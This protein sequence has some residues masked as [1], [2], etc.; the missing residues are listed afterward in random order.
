MTSPSAPSRF[1]L[2][3]LLQEVSLI[4]ARSLQRRLRK[5]RTPQALTAIAKDIDRAR[6]LVAARDGAIGEISYPDELPVSAYREEIAD[7]IRDNQVVIIAG[8]TGSGK[9]TQIPKICL[10]LG[11]GRRGLIGHTQPRRLAA[12]TVAERIAHELGQPVGQTVGYAIR[13][14]DTVARRTAV[15]LMTD[16]ILL[17]EMQHDRF[18]NAYD[19][20][21]IDEAHERS[22]NIDFLLGYIKKLLPQRP[23]LKVIITSAT[24]DPE[25]FAHHFC[26]ADGTPAP[27]IEVSGRTYPVE[28]RYRP[29]EEERNG[30]TYAVDPLDGLTAALEELMKEGPGDILC[31]FPSERDIRDAMEVIGAKKWRGVEVTPLFGRLS[32]QEQHRVFSPHRGRRIVLAT[33]IAETSLTVPGIHYVIDTGTARI[34]RYSTRTK[35]Q[36]LPIE[37]ISQASAN[38]RS[39][40]C[41]RIAEGIA[42]R[43]YSEED[44]LSRPEFTDPEILRTNLASVI[45]RMASLRLGAVEDFPFVEAPE[46]RAVRDGISLLLELGAITQRPSNGLPR[47]TAIGRDLAR[48]PVDPRLARMLVEAHRLGCL[49]PTIVIVAALSLQDIRER[50]LDYQAQ[51]D[52]LHARFKDKHSDFLSYLKLWEY[53]S[54]QR[55]ELSGNA[56]RKKLKKE[57][58]H[59]MRSREWQDLVRQLRDVC[60]QLSWQ[61]GAED[62]SQTHPDLLHRALLSGLLMNIG[63]RDGNKKEYRGTRGSRFA[64]FPGSSLA[65]RPPEFVMAAELVETSRLWARD[66][67]EIDPS[68]VEKLGGDAVKYQYS[69]PF[70]SRSQ[71]AVLV[72]RSATYYGVPIIFDRTIG[73][74]KV[75]PEAARDLFIR[76]ALVDGDWDAHH[77]FLEHNAQAL[78]QASRVEDKARRRGII[79]DEDALTEF[80]DA[81][82][83]QT[84]TTAAAFN[85]WWKKQRHRNAELLNFDPQALIA[86]SETGVDEHQFPDSWPYG[87]SAL[88]LRYVFS[89]GDPADGVSVLIPV[90]MLADVSESEFHW[91]VPGMR[92]ELVTELL[93]TLP[94]GLRRSVVPVP[95]F[96]ARITPLL[97]VNQPDITVAL[98]NAL[99]EAGVAGIDATDFRPAAVPPHLRM[100]YAAVDKAGKIIDSD[101]DLSALRQRQARHIASSVHKLSTATTEASASEWTADTLGTIAQE[102]TTDVDGHPVTA[103]PALVVS[104]DSV[105]V[106]VM[107]TR[108]AADAAMLT[109]TLTLLLQRTKLS[110][111]Q[112]VKG[113]PLQQ[114]VSVENYPHGGASGLVEEVRVGAVRDALV[115]HGGPVRDPDAFAALAKTVIPE[116]APQVRRDI[117]TLAPALAQY[118]KLTAELEQWEGPAIDDMN[119]Q[120]EFLLPPKA[121]IVH[122]MGHLKHLSRYLTAMEIRLQDMASNPDR[123]AQRQDEIAD[124]EQALDQVLARKTPATAKTTAVKDIRWMIQELRVS[125]FA[126]RLGTA[127][128]VSRK[129]VLNAIDKVARHR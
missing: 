106:R 63:A 44:F 121:V 4:D 79:A 109:A 3:S 39:G 43:L 77:K 47:L 28:V 10:E 120:L 42:I 20:I 61:M 15:K 76:H 128:P 32:N 35:V 94:K 51:A 75:D 26:S 40:R 101:K 14:D 64:I 78:D 8:E 6:S 118:H 57:F 100:T 45:L 115:R 113:L 93:R 103:Y 58:L 50:P 38:Q 23:D 18:F 83:P 62:T 90:P 29:L 9:T 116:V 27:I 36:R 55:A 85:T 16:G 37:E 5:A 110:A 17:A 31:F 119:R 111:P 69:E 104:G 107:P 86:P 105:A 123:D 70:W 80:Y 74:Q 33:N 72:H 67:A 92:E 52:Q 24:I 30:K 22:L 96:A 12:R 112:M 88:D 7:A 81:R 124:V 48:I 122:G 97:D 73:Y 54:T 102:V 49:A 126:Q 11:R 2:E 99:R 66:V 34:S 68:W 56:Y 108:A 89:P 65:K 71:S 1:D 82:I 98:A 114:R 19:T 84:I 91:L 95:D 87:D 53:L 127:R 25:R 129:R 117:V 60:K 21:I 125:L 59:F 41:G 13:F 46:P